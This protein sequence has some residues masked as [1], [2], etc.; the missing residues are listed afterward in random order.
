MAEKANVVFSEAT[1][2]VT[3]R[4]RMEEAEYMESNED[5]AFVGLC[6]VEQCAKQGRR[7][8]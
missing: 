5:S 6:A 8:A 4:A 7:G 2:R 3:S 1:K